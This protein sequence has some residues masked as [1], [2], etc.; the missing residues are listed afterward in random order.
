MF[1]SFIF[2]IFYL[3]GSTFH[4]TMAYS[5][6]W[7]NPMKWTINSSKFSILSPMTMGRFKIESVERNTLSFSLTPHFLKLRR[8]S[9][10][11]FSNS[12]T[13]CFPLWLYVIPACPFTLI[14]VFQNQSLC[15][16]VSVKTTLLFVIQCMHGKPSLTKVCLVHKIQVDWLNYMRRKKKI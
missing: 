10:P 5:Y 15:F 14:W 16:T 11:P 4:P 3:L 1:Y 8:P 2:L 13:Y 12:A 7:L 6:A 9:P